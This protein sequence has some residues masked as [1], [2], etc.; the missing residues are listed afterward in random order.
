MHLKKILNPALSIMNQLSFKSKIISSISILF[1]L[2]VFPSHT[3]FLNHYK[4]NN[5]YKQQLV[6][7]EYIKI[8]HKIIQ[9]IQVHRTDTN[10]YLNGYKNKKDDIKDEEDLLEMKIDSIYEYD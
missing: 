5:I 9:T 1:I 2:L 10:S 8:I 7:L 4:E 3:I 6:G